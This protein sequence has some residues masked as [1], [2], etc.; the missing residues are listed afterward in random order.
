MHI[1]ALGVLVIPR[2]VRTLVVGISGVTI[3]RDCHTSDLGSL[4]RNDI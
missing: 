2:P 3:P 4:V 1:I